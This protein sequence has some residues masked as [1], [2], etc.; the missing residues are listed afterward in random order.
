MLAGDVIDAVVW[1]GKTA[2]N[3]ATDINSGSPL[4]VNVDPAVGR[5]GAATE[6][7]PA[8]SRQT[9]IPRLLWRSTS[10]W[11]A[12]QFGFSC[13]LGARESTRASPTILH[14]ECHFV[15]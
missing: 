9:G 10:A 2:K 15:R 5:D 8:D 14:S 13:T 1:K 12:P 6:M 4:A 7:D 11:T 3:V